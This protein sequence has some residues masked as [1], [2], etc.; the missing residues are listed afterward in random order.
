MSGNEPMDID[1]AST[2]MA[3]IVTRHFARQVEVF[4]EPII[5]ICVGYKA[6]LIA[7]GVYEPAADLAIVALHEALIKRTFA[8]LD[9]V[10]EGAGK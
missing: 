10:I 3:G 8:E 9:K 5:D 2:V 4:A 1:E 6:K 7:A